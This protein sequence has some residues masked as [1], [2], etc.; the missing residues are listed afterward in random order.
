MFT[1]KL[2]LYALPCPVMSN[3]DIVYHCYACVW[4]ICTCVQCLSNLSEKDPLEK[5]TSE[6]TSYNLSGSY[7]T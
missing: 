7:Q 2:L 3:H 5:D 1:F 4:Y 6:V